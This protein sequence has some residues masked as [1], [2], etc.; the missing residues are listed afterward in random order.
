M[1]ALHLL[2]VIFSAGYYNRDEQT[3]VLQIV[4]VKLGMF[5]SQYLDYQHLSAIRTWFHPTLYIW[6]AKLYL[7][8][9]PLNPFHLATLFRLASSLLGIT[10]LWYLYKSFKNTFKTEAETNTFFFFL[11]TMWFLP[12][13]HARTAN[14]NLTTSFFI[15]GLYSLTKNENIKFAIFA[16]IFFALS[17]ITRFQMCVMIATTVLWFLIFNKYSWKNFA[18]LVSSFAL[19]LGLSTLID[20]WFYGHFTFTPYNYFKVNIIEKYVAQF[21]TSHWYEYIREGFKSGFPPLSLVFI[22][23][24]IILWIKFPKSLL[25]WVTLPFF[26]VHSLI[27]HKE[28]RFIFPIIFFLPVILTFL[29]GEFKINLRKSWVIAYLLLSIPAMLY[30]S[31]TPASNLINFNK[32]LYNKPD[33]INKMYVSTHFDEVAKFYLKNDIEYIEY[34][35]EEVEKLMNASGKKYFFTMSLADRDLVLTHSQCKK[36]FSLFPDWIYEFDL[37]KKRR[38]F[39][40]W[41]VVECS[42]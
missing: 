21:G 15:F 5:G 28:L 13:L 18:V 6:C 25:T 35:P 17:F 4:G 30:T 38:T 37:I 32:Y 42:N 14:E 12:F 29:I 20:T 41:T 11:A 39:K 31:L 9:F 22:T 33:R 26:V 8:F 10:S 24:F 7:L 2:A 40:S 36:D 3:Q 27:G 16:G 23:A 19:V 34:K 1:I